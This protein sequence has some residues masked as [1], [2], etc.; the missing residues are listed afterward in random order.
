MDRLRKGYALAAQRGTDKRVVVQFEDNRHLTRLLGEF[1]SH[2]ALIEDRLGIGAQ[3]HGN[4]VILTGADAPVS[5]ARKVLEQNY[6]RVAKGETVGPGD[7]DGLIRHIRQENAPTDGQAQ[8]ATRR[9][10]ITEAER[11]RGE[12]RPRR[13]KD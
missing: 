10:V 11:S 2:L 6:D 13:K 4:Q 12:Q 3:A 1:D 5:L 7:F 8:I 9:R